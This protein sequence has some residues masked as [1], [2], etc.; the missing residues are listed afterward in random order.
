MFPLIPNKITFFEPMAKRAY[1]LSS[2]NQCWAIPGALGHSCRRNTGWRMP[3]QAFP[4]ATAFANGL[5]R[6]SVHPT[7][8]LLPIH[9]PHPAPAAPPRE[10]PTAGF[11]PHTYCVHSTDE[12][13]R[14][15]LRDFSW[16]VLGA[17]CLRKFRLEDGRGAAHAQA[18]VRLCSVRLAEPADLLLA[19]ACALPSVPCYSTGT[20]PAARTAA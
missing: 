4:L 5:K 12:G 15:E 14:V 17:A 9:P 3:L 6:E 16:W 11:M 20:L 1:L 8:C 19:T 13:V 2:P 10:Y 7:T 18:P